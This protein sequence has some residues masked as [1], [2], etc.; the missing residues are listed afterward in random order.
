M[1][2]MAK[3]VT[4]LASNIRNAMPSLPSNCI[5]PMANSNKASASLIGNPVQQAGHRTPN[6]AFVGDID[7]RS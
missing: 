6:P 2:G 7:S 5:V 1:I 3:T 4:G